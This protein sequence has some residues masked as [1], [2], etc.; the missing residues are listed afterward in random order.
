MQELITQMESTERVESAQLNR[1]E[2]IANMV[3]KLALVGSA[4]LAISVLTH[5]TKEP[6]GSIDTSSIPLIEHT[7]VP[8]D[9]NRIL[10]SISALGMALVGL[11]AIEVARGQSEDNQ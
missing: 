5:D 8:F 3:A 10:E 11:G 9:Q 2:R 4:L 1:T 7:D 6:I